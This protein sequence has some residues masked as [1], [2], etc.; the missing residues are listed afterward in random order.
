MSGNV[1]L[2][3]VLSA[4][5]GPPGHCRAIPAQFPADPDLELPGTN[6][7]RKTPT[8][9]SHT[10]KVLAVQYHSRM[11]NQAEKNCPSFCHLGEQLH[12]L[13]L[14]LKVDNSVCKK[15]LNSQCYEFEA[16]SWE[17]TPQA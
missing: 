11:L 12:L 10:L 3:D 14:A 1:S 4:R 13:G 6:E 7:L 2:S 16:G 8:Y 17:K 9:I 5:F 15:L